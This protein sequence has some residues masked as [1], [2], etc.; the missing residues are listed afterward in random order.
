MYN[1]T[2]NLP[3]DEV[4]ELYIEIQSRLISV[5]TKRSSECYSFALSGYGLAKTVSLY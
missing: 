4:L 5:K 1:G 2:P 3:V